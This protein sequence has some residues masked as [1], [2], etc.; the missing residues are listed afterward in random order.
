M[1]N[2]GGYRGYQSCKCISIKPSYLPLTLHHGPS[3][4]PLHQ[5]SEHCSGKIKLYGTGHKESVSHFVPALIQWAETLSSLQRLAFDRHAVVFLAFKP[6]KS[7]QN[8]GVPLASP[9][10]WQSANTKGQSSTIFSSCLVSCAKTASKC[11][12][13]CWYGTVK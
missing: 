3:N 12:C 8:I 1:H 6:L 5:T 11:W 9:S 7:R 4:R 13:W 10:P 2:W